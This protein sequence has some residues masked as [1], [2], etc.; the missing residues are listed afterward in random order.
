MDSRFSRKWSDFLGINFKKKTQTQL[1]QARSPK[2]IGEEYFFLCQFMG[3]GLLYADYCFGKVP[4]LGI[5]FVA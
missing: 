4:I 2:Q 5:A 1:P 3:N